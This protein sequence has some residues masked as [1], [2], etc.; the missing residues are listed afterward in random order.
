MGLVELSRAINDG[1]SG[2]KKINSNR[3]KDGKERK[4]DFS[5][6]CGIFTRVQSV[7][8]ALVR[9]I[10]KNG[11][12]TG[13]ITEQQREET[14]NRI[15]NKPS[16]IINGITLMIGVMIALVILISIVLPTINSA[17]INGNL[18]GTTATVVGII[19]LMIAVGFLLLII[20][21]V[22]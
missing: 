11:E 4:L 5:G 7:D 18:T 9:V 19:P 3:E 13:Y 10:Y 21:V 8:G 2:G 14:L 22:V 20:G 16:Q 17:V 15:S 1:L 6:S 12:P